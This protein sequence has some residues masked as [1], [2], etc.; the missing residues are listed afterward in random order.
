M[1]DND[2]IDSGYKEC[3]MPIIKHASRFFQKRFDDNIGKK[4][5]IDIYRY[6]FPDHPYTSGQGHNHSV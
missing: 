1:T 5:F 3:S 2:I 6:D 4:Y